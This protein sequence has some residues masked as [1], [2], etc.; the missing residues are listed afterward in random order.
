[1]NA[2]TLRS[3]HSLRSSQLAS[4]SFTERLVLVMLVATVLVGCQTLPD[5]E[6]RTQRDAPQAEQSGG[7]VAVET[8]IVRVR[9]LDALRS[10]TGTTQ[11]IQLVSVRAQTEGRLL[12]LDADVGDRVRQSQTLG[13]IDDRILAAL[14]NQARAELAARESEVAQAQAEVNAAE[15]EVERDRLELQQLTS[16]AE[17]LAQLAE[18]GAVSAQQAEQA[19]TAKLTAERAVQ[20]AEQ[21]VRTRQQAV[22]ATRGRVKAQAAAIAEIRQQQAHALLQSPIAGV[23]LE[24]SK[25]AGDLARPGEEILTVG[26]FNDVKV[27]VQVSELDLG[28]IRLRQ[29][30]RV[31]LDAFPA[32]MFAGIVER[33]SPVADEAARLVP[34]EVRVPNRDRLI[35]SG[36]L[37]RVQFE[38]EQPPQ[39]T[40][41]EA[42]LKVG[43]EGFESAVFAVE[44]VGETT[45]ASARSV[46][47]GERR[48][49]FVQVR[50]GL[51]PEEAVVVNSSQPLTDGQ[52]VRLSL[53]SEQPER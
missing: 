26:D 28:R 49:G 38:S 42:A 8:A 51:V 36:L 23:V 31:T 16:D 39:I 6:A 37:A 47:L 21:Q 53:L 40:I 29:S 48:N 5:S 2:E 4:I 15:T 19:E 22:A 9:P 34:V 10:Y 18:E 14:L 7:A 27:V 46:V 35:V 12:S 17:R 3:L 33:I 43:G 45:Q 1:M 50:S 32:Q 20:S 30:A 25:Q 52:P 41:P 11:P 24:R 44:T 13:Q